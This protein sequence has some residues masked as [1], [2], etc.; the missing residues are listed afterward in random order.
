MRRAACVCG[1]AHFVVTSLSRQRCCTFWG[2]GPLALLR[3]LISF[4]K[5]TEMKKCSG[6]SCSRPHTNLLLHGSNVRVNHARAQNRVN[7][8]WLKSAANLK[9]TSDT[10]VQYTAEAMMLTHFAACGLPAA[11]WYPCEGQEGMRIITA[12]S[13]PF[14]A[15]VCCCTRRGITWAIPPRYEMRGVGMEA[16]LQ[17]DVPSHTLLPNVC[18]ELGR[19]P[20]GRA[21]KATASEY[22]T[23]AET[24]SNVRA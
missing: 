2:L 14:E 7:S 18:S 13:F 6:L 17:C 19:L 24:K 15:P 1:A 23:R 11:V 20:A 8:L 10:A 16:T 3:A 21:C 22:P 12:D 5:V 9:W 4:M